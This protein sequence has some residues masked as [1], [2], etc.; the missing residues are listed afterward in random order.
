MQG[1]L[2]GSVALTEKV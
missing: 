2:N 1:I